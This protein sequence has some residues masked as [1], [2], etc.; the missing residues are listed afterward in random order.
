MDWGPKRYVQEVI[1]ILNQYE[2]DQATG[3]ILNGKHRMAMS[4]QE[5]IEWIK[6]H[7]EINTSTL[8]ASPTNQGKAEDIMQDLKKL[9]NPRLQYPR[10]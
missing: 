8:L 1:D 5:L 3:R 7:E 2:A 10:Q 4:K 6:K 9:Y